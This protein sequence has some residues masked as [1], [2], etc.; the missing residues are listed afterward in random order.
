MESELDYS[1]VFYRLRKTDSARATVAQKT[2]EAD[3]LEMAIQIASN[4]RK[5]LEAPQTPDGVAIL[6]DAGLE[7]CASNFEE[8]GTGRRA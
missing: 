8:V 1:I 2:V 4:L 6:D 5:E 7:L 3:D